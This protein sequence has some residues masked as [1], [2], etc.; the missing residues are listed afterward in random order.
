MTKAAIASAKPRSRASLSRAACASSL[1][2]AFALGSFGFR[3]SCLFR[4]VSGGLRVHFGAAF[5]LGS[6]GF[7]LSCLFRYVA[8]GSCL[9]QP[10]GCAR[11]AQHQ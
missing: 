4:L 10:P 6:L 8:L 11:D 9:N 2:A 5:A 3:L 7:R 1:C